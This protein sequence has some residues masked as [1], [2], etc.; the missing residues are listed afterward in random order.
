MVRGIKNLQ[1]KIN[2]SLRT[3]KKDVTMNAIVILGSFI[4]A[5]KISPVSGKNMYTPYCSAYNGGGPS[6]AY[7]YNPLLM[8]YPYNYAPSAVYGNVVP[9]RR[10][11]K[12][13]PRNKDKI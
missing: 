11:P 5:Y 10:K 6:K 2:I 12:N 8:H 9:V 4:N 3:K 1:K 7:Y 13:K